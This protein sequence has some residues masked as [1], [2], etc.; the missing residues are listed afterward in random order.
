MCWVH[1]SDKD[2]SEWYSQQNKQKKNCEEYDTTDLPVKE[3]NTLE[4]SVTSDM[5]T[6]GE[7]EETD[8]WEI[9]ANDNA[10]MYVNSD[11]NPEDIDDWEVEMGV[12]RHHTHPRN[13]EKERKKHHKR[14]WNTIVQE[15]KEFNWLKKVEIIKWN[16]QQKVQTLDLHDITLVIEDIASQAQTTMAEEQHTIWI[17]ILKKYRTTNRELWTWKNEYVPSEFLKWVRS[18][19]SQLQGKYN[20]YDPQLYPEWCV[21]KSSKEYVMLL[22]EK[23]PQ[24][25]KNL[26]RRETELGKDQLPSQN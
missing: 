24:W 11:D 6:K 19:K 15:T 25:F 10:W 22:Q 13:L 16:A 20:Q 9:Q 1:Q 2:S 12:K 18:L 7:I 8:N 5:S 26:W 21:V 23:E 3:L 4:K 14:E 17:S